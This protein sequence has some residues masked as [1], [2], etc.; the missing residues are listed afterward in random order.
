L[1]QAFYFG[2][3][4]LSVQHHR[5][6]L[7]SGQRCIDECP[8][9]DAGAIWP[10]KAR[11][12]GLNGEANPDPPER[13]TFTPEQITK[14]KEIIL[15]PLRNAPDGKRHRARVDVAKHLGG[16]LQSL[17]M[18]VAEAVEALLDA[19]PPSETG[20]D[21]ERQAIVDG[22]A[23]GLAAPL[24]LTAEMQR[25]GL[26]P[27]L[28]FKGVKLEP[29][30]HEAPSSQQA[31][32]DKPVGSEKTTIG[33]MVARLNAQ[34]MVVNEAG[35]VV[36][37]EPAYDAVTRRWRHN[38]ITFDDF[39]RL[40]CNEV[41]QVGIKD[42]TPRMAPIA[43]VWLHH[44]NRRQY[45]GGVIFDPSCKH[46]RPDALNLWKGFAV[47]P[48]QGSWDLLRS[49][50][51]ATLCA[52]RSDAYIYVV[53][54][55]ARLVQHPAEHGWT[56]LVFRG[57]EGSGKGLLPTFAIRMLGQ[58][59]LLI[60]NP[61]H[62]TGA[63]NLH[64]QDCILLF[65]DEAFHAGDKHHISVLKALVTEPSFTVEAK[66]ANPIT[67]PNY[68]HIIMASND[69]WVVPA[70]IESRRFAVMDVLADRVGDHDYF[71]AI[72]DQMETGGVEAM[73]HD[74]VAHRYLW[75]QRARHSSN[76]WSA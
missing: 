11:K 67:Q 4:E 48:R 33:A 28:D 55:L 21:K 24:S 53:N 46:V 54:W 61:K 16:L 12:P 76:G 37:H 51:H 7:V 22:L 14:L 72:I 35:R 26:A 32:P 59:G 3:V 44:R 34:Y 20:W 50:I 42:G 45:P 18:T 5:V 63:F 57:V 60:S 36:I 27:N 64:L 17:K 52:G 68:L 29:P 58:H 66:Y 39:K 69:D 70:S 30:P 8:E 15:A 23:Y 10:K 56:V 6:E 2:A 73:L 19:K 40:Y 43:V 9:L 13:H 47:E 31:S 38:R 75:L 65:A 62:L 1:S 41:V 49:H 71:N 74:T 25:Y